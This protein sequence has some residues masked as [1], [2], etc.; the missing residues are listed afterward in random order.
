MADLAWAC[1]ADADLSNA[2]LSA[3]NLSHADLRNAN[4]SGA[5]LLVTDLN[6]AHLVGA[7]FTHVRNLTADQ[8][9]AARYDSTTQLDEHIVSMLS[10]SSN[11]AQSQAAP[12]TA[13]L[14]TPEEGETP[15][16]DTPSLSENATEPVDEVSVDDKGTDSGA[17]AQTEESLAAS[18]EA[19]SSAEENSF[20]EKKAVQ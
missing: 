2:D 16:Q 4:L 1:L 9:R 17:E 7:R 19:V 18:Q 13:A 12:A 11:S 8:L 5:N 15:V 14:A 3:S 6:D 20:H 10:S